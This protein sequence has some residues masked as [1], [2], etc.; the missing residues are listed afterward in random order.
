MELFSSLENNILFF[1]NIKATFKKQMS[2]KSIKFSNCFDKLDNEGSGF[3][4]LNNL[5]NM[6]MNYKDGIFRDQIQE[7]SLNS[8]KII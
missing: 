1:L 6:L 2:T 3:F 7:G 8:S 5:T 4:N